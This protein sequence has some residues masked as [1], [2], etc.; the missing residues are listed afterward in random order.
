M[1]W[2]RKPRKPSPKNGEIRVISK[3]AL[4]PVAVGTEVRWLEKVV[5][6]QTFKK[7]YV[8]YEAYDCEC[9]QNTR[10]LN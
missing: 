2:N 5:V 6:E 9:W 8:N 1:K 10:F 3:F 7:D 4:L